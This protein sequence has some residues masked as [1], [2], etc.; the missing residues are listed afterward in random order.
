M[1]ISSC[2]QKIFL[3]VFCYEL[4]GK[5]IHF[6]LF[7]IY[8]LLQVKFKKPKKKVRKVRKR[9]VLKVLLIFIQDT[10]ELTQIFQ[11]IF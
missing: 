4:A 1:K 11:Q 10:V 3:Q 9:A 8:F 6:S 7:T 2:L 5:K